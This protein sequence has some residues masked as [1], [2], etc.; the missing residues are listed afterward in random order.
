VNT[1]VVVGA[2][3]GLGLSI[4]RKF[5]RSGMRVALISRKQEKLD[6]LVNILRG[7]NIEAWGFAGDVSDEA[8]IASALQRAEAQC[9]PIEVLEYSPLP[10]MGRDQNLMSA[11]GTTVEMAERQ[12]RRLALGA[13]ATVRHVIP[14]MLQR[15]RGAILITTSGSGYFPIEILTPIGM[16]MAALRQ[17]AYCLNQALSGTGVFAGTVC[18]AIVIRKGDEQADP[19]TIAQTYL[20]LYERRDRTEVILAPPGGEDALK[21]HREDLIAR[22]ITPVLGTQARIL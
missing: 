15:K 21:V 14:G 2:G 16:A 1:A 12:Y 6:T 5:G 10:G 11:L 17:Y 22:G 9:G 7:E 19:D 13:I 8:S 20:D 3:P 18:I 4:G